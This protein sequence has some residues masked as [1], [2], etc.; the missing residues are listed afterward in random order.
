MVKT[1]FLFK[2][3]FV[4]E[5]SQFDLCFIDEKCIFLSQQ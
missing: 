3:F 2:S 4:K 5:L 1:V